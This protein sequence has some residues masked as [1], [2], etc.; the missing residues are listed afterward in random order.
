MELP[1][2]QSD[3][4]RRHQDCALFIF[5]RFPAPGR[6][7]TRLIPLLGDLGAANL[8]K[9]MTEHLVNHLQKIQDLTLQVH[10]TGG[11]RSQMRTWLGNQL[12]L[13]AQS[14]GDLGQRLLTAFQQ[15]FTAGLQRIVI[16][17]SDCPNLNEAHITQA[18]ALLHTHEVVF[19]PATDG[20]YYLIGLSHMCPALF[21]GIA[22]GSDRDLTQTQ[23]IAGQQNL[24]TALLPQHSDVDRPEDLH[25]WH[26]VVA[27]KEALK[28]QFV[29]NA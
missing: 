24:S 25:L 17:G 14:E 7:K 18:L 16:I 12:T 15:G 23:V 10:F 19:G 9:Q 27:E 29:D 8:Q 3:R 2:Q 20:G 28:A 13:V 21:D 1:E 26:Q 4:T 22:W 5:T 6:T 11:T